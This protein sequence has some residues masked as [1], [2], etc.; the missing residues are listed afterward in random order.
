MEDY[1]MKNDKYLTLVIRVTE[2]TEKHGIESFNQLKKAGILNQ[3]WEK[4]AEVVKN[5][6]YNMNVGAPLSSLWMEKWKENSKWMDETLDERCPYADADG[7][8]NMPS[9]RD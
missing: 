3:D 8:V 1:R 7:Y 5:M 9:K 4:A 6:A 2:W